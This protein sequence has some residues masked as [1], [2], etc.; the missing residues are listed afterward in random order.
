MTIEELKT[1]FVYAYQQ[2]ADAVYFVPGHINL[3]GEHAHSNNDSHISSA[4]SFGIYCLNSHKGTKAHRGKGHC[5]TSV[6][7]TSSNYIVCR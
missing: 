1:A 4:L 3:I 7:P 6:S 5:I 2:K